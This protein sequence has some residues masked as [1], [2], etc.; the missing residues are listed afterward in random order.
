M[1]SLLGFGHKRYLK[2]KK[3]LLNMKYL[4]CPDLQRKSKSCNLKKKKDAFNQRR[5]EESIK[6]HFSIT[7]SHSY[8]HLHLGD[9]WFNHSALRKS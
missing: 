1:E 3:S 9:A 8:T 2:I 4:K 6:S 5:L 7:G